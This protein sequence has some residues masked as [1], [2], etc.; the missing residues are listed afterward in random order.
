MRRSGILLVVLCAF[1]ALVGC[2][3]S[4]TTTE[5]TANPTNSNTNMN[6]EPKGDSTS[7]TEL[8]KLE[9]KDMAETDKTAETK[10]S[11][12]T[13][14]TPSGLKFIEVKGGTGP[15][16]KQGQRVFVHY[17]GTLTNGKKFDS[18]VDRGQPLDFILGA[19]QV[20]PG[21]D[22]GIATMRV[23][24]KRKLIIPP[25]LAYGA[26]GAGDAIPPNATLHFDVEL[27]KAENTN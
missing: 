14:T 5:N 9:S 27:I 6:F 22:E 16:P 8:P 13:E 12:K 25:D 21:W 4:T 23:G 1:V 2:N 11:G 20:I 26:R 17:T 10:V 18:S 15:L 3:D 24:G 19:G 7:K